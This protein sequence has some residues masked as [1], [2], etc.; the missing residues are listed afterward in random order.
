MVPWRRSLHVALALSAVILSFPALA[1][2]PNP[3]CETWAARLISYQGTLIGRRAS[4]MQLVSV[5]IS[6][7]FCVGDVLEIG[8][9]SRAA[10]QLPDQTVVR[11][12]QGTIVT[13]ATPKDDK[14]TW[15]DILKGAI[16][17]ISR[18][19]RAL[20]VI[21][22]FANAGIEGTEFLVRVDVDTALVLV[23]EGSVKVANPLGE[24]TAG[25]GQSVLARSGSAP[26]LQQVVRPR[27]Q[28]VWTLYYP[29]LSSV[30]A[31][32]SAV[33]AASAAT[34]TSL[35]DLLARAEQ[36]LAVGR[37]AE[38]EADL[39]EALKLEP[40]S[41]EV[42]ARQSVIALTRNDAA[43]AKELADRAA[44]AAPTSAAARLA[45]S[46]A[47][48]SAGDLPGAI[49]SLEAASAANP[50]D[51]LLRARLAELWLASGDYGRSE[52][53]AKA[54]IAA[55]P[56]LGLARTVQGFID[57]AKV[58]IA[59]A[60]SSFQAAI[61]REPNAPLP[62]LGLGLAKIRDGY[63]AAGREEIETAVILNPNDSLVRSYMGKAYYEEKR[64]TLAASQLEFAKELDPNDPTPWFYDAIRKQTVNRP[65][66]ALSDLQNSA[67]LNDRRGV[68]RSQLLLDD[69]AAARNAS[70]SALFRELGFEALAVVEGTRALAENFGNSSAHRLLANAY[71]GLPRY[72]ISR[73]SEAF[74]AQVRQPLSVPS[75]GLSETQENLGI[76]R[77]AG[78][79]R[80]GSNEYNSLFN[81][82]QLR[83]EAEATA[84]SRDTWGQQFAASGLHERL[85]FSVEQLHYETDGFGDNNRAERDIY[86][87]FLQFQ[88]NPGTSLQLDL[89][90]SEFLLG[91][92]F[93]PYD[94]FLILPVEVDE[95]ADRVRLNGRHVTSPSSDWVWTVGYENRQRDAIFP[96]LS[97][98]ITRT[99]AKTYT[100]EVQ[101]L[102]RLGDM[103]LISGL[104]YI[105][106]DEDFPIELN[107]IDTY[108]VN[109][110][111][112]A[113]ARATDRLTLIGGVS[114]DVFEQEYSAFD[115]SIE[116]TQ[117]SPKVGVV[118]TP[119]KSTTVRAAAFTSVR[120]PFIASQTLEPTLVGGFNQFFTGLETFYG[121]PEGT[122]SRRVGGAIEERFTD[123]LF[124][125]AEWS[126]RRLE[127]P[128]LAF[129]GQK[130][131]SWR[132]K[133]GR[134]YLYRTFALSE[135]SRWD[136]T[137]SA[138]AEY[139]ELMR[140]Q[141]L[142]GSE[143]IID[144]ETTRVPFG[145]AFFNANG[146]TFRVTMGYVRQEGLFSAD[147]GFPIVPIE[148][149][150]WIT[151][152]SL[153]FRLPKRFGL[154]SLVARNVFD[155]EL[156][157]ADTD[158]LSPR[159]ARRRWVLASLNVDF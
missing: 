154:L 57:L 109:A 110:Y 119:T 54:A 43:T 39:A 8:P 71:A 86:G 152:V 106:A 126:V 138:A 123:Q 140:P 17:V 129:S 66:E 87:G 52:A 23:Y 121:D 114:L 9:F 153:E 21:T 49:D 45:Q 56:D 14:R 41:A 3:G 90:H 92:T 72:D 4:G 100:A 31:S 144:L 118:W 157:V 37:I 55:N 73:V 143:A 20:R 131:F 107:E 69:D 142:T 158:P 150:E 96:E 2:S 116:R 53:N 28:V 33:G 82:D 30:S 151:D 139:E 78:P 18:D 155:E 19:P 59:A 76:L 25:S 47:R 117:I 130:D 61:E 42:L 141:I 108:N 38:A 12:D 101:H 70:V 5:S 68:Y 156:N 93:Y 128:F 105:D 15:L 88:S 99:D 148:D 63:L 102:A 159:D 125:G 48:Q 137:L 46:Y 124:A 147:V 104:G 64:D 146:V 127:V 84:G 11:L 6:D 36:R 103:Q 80:V 113:Q 136:V 29:P 120:R 35:A 24:A 51:A 83:I 50:N 34:T 67:E 134:A 149:D 133:A 32:A 98:L 27:D 58:D 60:K 94:E 112:Y 75:A 95:E 89:R 132:E 145:A 111:V 135:Q 65:V 44:T 10:I 97:L 115:D 74:Q 7:T 22:P 77:D 40:G 122:I 91:F 85:G 13:F 26:V 79:S 62:R 16:H 1:Q 81:R